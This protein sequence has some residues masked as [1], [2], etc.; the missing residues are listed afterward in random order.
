MACGEAAR[1]RPGS[2]KHGHSLV[3]IAADFSPSSPTPLTVF[4]LAVSSKT[5]K[6][7]SRFYRFD[8]LQRKQAEYLSRPNCLCSQR[9][10]GEP[11]VSV[12][13]VLPW[14]DPRVVHCNGQNSFLHGFKKYIWAFSTLPVQCAA[15]KSRLSIKGLL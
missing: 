14:D 7:R 1:R 15:D 4:S 11:L 5:S 9:T 12:A 13:H 8:V 3:R 2:Y 6:R 10:R